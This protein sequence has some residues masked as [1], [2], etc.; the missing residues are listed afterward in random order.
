VAVNCAEISDELAAA[1]FFGHRKGSFTGA[2]ADE[3]GLFRA[4]HRGVLF[5]DE[6]A[7]L[8]LRAQATLLRVLENRTVVPVGETREIRVDV[9]VVLA[10]NRDPEKAVAGG[11]IKDDLFER[12]RVQAIELAPL[13]DRPWDVPA[14]AQHFLA[15]HERRTRKKTLGLTR[16]GMRALVAYAWPG[17][18]RELARLC[19]LLVTH[20][21]AGARI[22]EALL[23]Q[24]YPSLLSGTPNP[25]AAP[26]LAGEMSMRKALRAFE[27]DLIRSRLEQH[28]WNLRAAR[29][30]L[31][32][33]KTTFRRYLVDLAIR[34]GRPVEPDVE[35]PEAAGG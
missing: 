20:A 28:N 12:F 18:V 13:R 4:A 14:L 19:S 8:G 32:L 17:N 29:D 11:L 30:S 15:H 25:Q 7:E 16:A 26:A 34:P 27:R 10:T 35:E 6:I 22:D 1:R 9:Q 23:R 33:P 3:P 2:V 24:C 21:P 31:K 5:L